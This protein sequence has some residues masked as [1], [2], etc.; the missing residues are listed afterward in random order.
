M[1]KLE[2]RVN[3]NAPAKKVWDIMLSPDTYREWTGV[4]W[5][6]STYEGNWKE[7]EDIRFIGSDGT[8][9]LGHFNEV[10]PYKYIACEHVAVLLKGGV[11]DRT[12]D[13]AKGWIGTKENYTF[14]EK[15][16]STEV[17]VEIHT[18]PAWEKMFNDGWPNA[19]DKLKE[20]AERN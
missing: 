14:T 10:K 6:S 20:M 19:L 8:G 18:N 5:P 17:Y 1:K 13:M 12:S 4:S 16:G 3:I 11:E 15:N 9:T 7:G 2:Y